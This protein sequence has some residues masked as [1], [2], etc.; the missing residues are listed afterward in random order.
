MTAKWRSVWTGEL[1]L[2]AGEPVASAAT[3]NAYSRP[4]PDPHDRQ[5]TSPPINSRGVAKSLNICAFRGFS[6][7]SYLSRESCA[8]ECFTP[9]NQ[10][11]ASS[12]YVE[13]ASSRPVR[14]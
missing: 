9:G 5:L 10:P 2:L 1:P 12:E 3:A 14:P 11:D 6:Q 8:I 7:D 4:A 13:F